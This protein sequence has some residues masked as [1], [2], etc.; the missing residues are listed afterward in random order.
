M[1]PF[2][3]LQAMSFRTKISL[4]IIGALLVLG[5]VLS[6]IMS[7]IVADALLKE[8]K[9]RGIATAV[10]LSARAEEPL[11]AT[12]LLQLKNLVDQTKTASSDISYSFVLDR[13]G[14]PIAHTF[15]GGFPV[16]L[17][18]ANSVP[19]GESHSIRLL[20][21]GGELIYDFAVPV[22]I[23]KDRL[24]TVRIGMSYAHVQGVVRKLIIAILLSTGAGIL[25]VGLTSTWLARTVT[26]R[27]QALHHSA[28]E[29]IKGN[30]DVQTA[31]LLKHRCWEVMNCEKTECPAYGDTRRRCWYLVGTLC[32]SC[33]LGQ[34][35]HKIGNCRVCEVYRSSSGDEI[36]HL[37]EFFDIMALTLKDRLDALSRTKENLRR[38]QQ[39][40][41]TILDVTPDLVCLKDREGRYKAVNKAFAA[42]VGKHEGDILGRY[43]SDVLPPEMAETDREEERWV[44]LTMQ[45]VQ[46]EKLVSGPAGSR[47]LHVVKTPVVDRNGAV[48]GILC[49][50][51][52]ITEMKELNETVIRS[53]RLDSIGQLA[54]GVAHEI[55]TPLGIIL[56]NVQLLIEDVAQGSEMHETLSTIEKYA[57]TCRNIVADL[58]RFS[59]HTESVKKP[60]DLNEMLSQLLSLV[61][62]T[63][64]LDRITVTRRLSPNLPLIYGDREKLEQV[65]MNLLNNAHDAI[66]SDGRVVVTTSCDSREGEVIVSVADTGKGIPP[67]IQ[68]RIFDPFFTTKAVGKGTGLGLSV[69]FGIVKD[70]SGRID[71]R[72]PYAVSGDGAT[73]A[74]TAGG[75]TVFRVT[76]P[77]Y[78][79]GIHQG[80][81]A[82]GT[83]TDTR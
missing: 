10:Y 49:T 82:D 55:N 13:N 18:T 28:E 43:D 46:G 65:F 19:D 26:R 38:Q 68:D 62:H 3:R 32:A 72:S 54:A 45:T 80:G 61:E 63:F 7:G 42:F 66:G 78:V 5:A 39:L 27:I 60:V 15:S 70:H 75:G 4:S 8:N 30:L 44:A 56:G 24:G 81:Q 25:V 48:E 36:Q 53:Q 50:S 79:G 69:T 41:Q 37:A 57:R 40:F 29:I 52:D 20:S 58:L 33:G 71:V 6:L 16:D 47:W 14:E 77:A 31:P 12:D 64:G 23:G 35:E 1:N 67:E 73:T 2:D 9:K 22:L 76:F 83:Y 74:P 51:R 17:R 34:Y 11:L 21:A 59:R